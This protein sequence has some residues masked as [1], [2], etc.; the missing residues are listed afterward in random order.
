[1]MCVCMMRSTHD[2]MHAA[3]LELLGDVYYTEYIEEHPPGAAGPHY[4]SPNTDNQ[5]N[6]YII[7]KHWTST[8]PN[9]CLV[10]E[11]TTRRLCLIS[12]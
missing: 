12:C 3:R 1:M 6:T 9:M 5:G 4:A 10:M 7:T 2:S 8:F 11:L